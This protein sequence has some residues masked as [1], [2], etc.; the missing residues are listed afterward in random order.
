[1]IVFVNL[2]LSLFAFL[3]GFLSIG[4]G[5]QSKDGETRCE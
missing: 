2:Q 5:H 1:M 3:L 4:K